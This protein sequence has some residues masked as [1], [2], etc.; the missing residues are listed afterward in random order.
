MTYHAYHAYHAPFSSAVGR[1]PMQSLTN[2]HDLPRIPRIPR[3]I[4]VGPLG[5]VPTKE[6]GP[7]ISLVFREMWDTTAFNHPLPRLTIDAQDTNRTHLP[8]IPR[9]SRTISVGR[10]GP[11]L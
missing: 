11:A 1:Q 5:S 4:S 10:G 9:I 3:T 8:R 2:P 7:H 6:D